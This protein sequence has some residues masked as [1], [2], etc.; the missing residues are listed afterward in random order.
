MRPSP[1]RVS[2]S[3]A[4][5]A[6]LLGGLLLLVS[7]GPAAATWSIV[8]VDPDT[9]EV[10]VAVAS[11]VSFNVASVP[12]LVPG[13]GA[14]ASQAAL[15][16]DSGDPIV[17]GLEEG[18]TA[19]EVIERLTA[20][21]VDPEASTR[22]YG[23]VTLDGT[24]AGHTG[25]DDDPVALDLQN[26]DAT[27]SAQGNILV[28]EAVVADTLA[29]FDDA[30]G[31]LADRLLAALTAGSEAGG[32]SR[33]GEETA[34]SAALIVARPGDPVWNS[35]ELVPGGDV[36]S[37][38]TPSVYVAVINRG[39]NPIPA[40]VAGYQDNRADDG[41]VAYSEGR[42]SLESIV[43]GTLLVGLGV[44]VLGVL[45]ALMLVAWRMLRRRGA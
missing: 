39:S 27:A 30:Q 17:A 33:C 13:R 7:A 15:N 3:R 25:A 41:S 45:V 29:A 6:S 2:S 43:R 9:G 28:A 20:A 34:N 37:L 10:G 21:D 1:R 12:V 19:A 44:V 24:A 35:T 14:A 5:A 8:G 42:S 22:Q 11:C 31:A 26:A 40:L 18:L 4:L 23:V 16:E 38:A 32:D 36:T